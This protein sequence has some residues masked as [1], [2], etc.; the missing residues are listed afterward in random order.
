MGELLTEHDGG[1]GGDGDGSGGLSPSRQ[2]AGTGTS[3]PRNLLSMAAELRNF[4]WNMTLVFRVF[5]LG[6]INRQQGGG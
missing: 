3:D 5:A 2:G 6:G 1:G 4:L